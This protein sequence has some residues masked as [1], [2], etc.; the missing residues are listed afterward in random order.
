MLLLKEDVHEQSL[1][2]PAGYIWMKLV[3][4]LIYDLT[5]KS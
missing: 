3:S 1:V 2:N 4:F 5:Q